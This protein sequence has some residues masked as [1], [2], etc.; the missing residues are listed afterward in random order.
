MFGALAPAHAAVAGAQEQGAAAGL[1]AAELALTVE[2]PRAATVRAAF[3]LEPVDAL[4][5]LLA[6]L[7]GQRL[8]EIEF[9]GPGGPISATMQE[10]SSALHAYTVQMPAGTREL[11]VRYRIDSEAAAAHRFA[12]P[13]PDAVPSAEG[14][15]VRLVVEL[16][17][18]A[19]FSGNAFPP[20]SS[21]D[22]GLLHATS[23][24]VPSLAHVVAGVG[25]LERNAHHVIEWAAILILGLAAAGTRLWTRRK[26]TGGPPA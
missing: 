17:P 6:Q 4:T 22:D 20:L 18:D 12:L 15:R 16:P 14:Q 26:T 13:V 21:G 2:S 9:T 7:P 25:P 10:R 3:D 19:A 11:S 5:V 23:V 8:S 1:V 24:A